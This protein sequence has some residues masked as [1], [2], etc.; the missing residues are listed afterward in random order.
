MSA[1]Q[2]DLNADLGEHP[3]ADGIDADARIL[4]GVS[5]ANVACGFHAGDGA[6]MRAICELAVR[7]HKRIGAHVSYLDRAGF[8][9]RVLDVTAETLREHILQ[10]IRALEAQAGLAGGAVTYV[11]AHGALYNRAAVDRTTAN[12]VATAVADASASLDRPLKLLCPPDSKLIRAAAEH[13]VDGIAEGF[14]DR[15]YQA[16][17]TL[18]PRSEPGSVLTPDATVAQAKLIATERRVVALDGTAL[19]LEVRSLCLHSDTPGA[20][21]LAVRLRN[22]LIGAGCEVR[23]FT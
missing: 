16:D 12:V 1:V 5:S 15:G 2:I 6:T 23:A 7:R 3:G 11:K 21:E 17:G 4:E 8:G 13:G 20:A 19:S 22:A 9:R 10:Q 18:T 14:A